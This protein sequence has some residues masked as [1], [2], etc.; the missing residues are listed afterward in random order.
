MPA[1]KAVCLYEA[2]L[3]ITQAELLLQMQDSD[4]YSCAR[5]ALTRLE[6][7]LRRLFQIVRSELTVCSGVRALVRDA[8]SGLRLV[9]EAGTSE[10]S[11]FLATLRDAVEQEME[12]AQVNDEEFNWFR[13]GLAIGA[14]S[15]TEASTGR[16]AFGNGGPRTV[17]GT[18][19][20]AVWQARDATTVERLLR[21]L[22]QDWGRLFPGFPSD[23]AVDDDSRRLLPGVPE[24]LWGWIALE[25]GLRN[26]STESNGTS[27]GGTS[28]P[29]RV[30][31]RGRRANPKVRERNR[32]IV[33]YQQGHPT[34]S[35]ERIVD[36]LLREYPDLT[37]HM[38]RNAL[39]A[40]RAQ[41]RN[42]RQQRPR[43]RGGQ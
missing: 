39:K 35:A 11:T 26:L 12:D 37:I 2:G 3:R 9:G 15:G 27:T 36:A 14:G 21:Q 5:A 18:A 31:Q 30:P 1:V 22:E 17:P 10:V 6:T 4:W 32:A 42:Q 24:H 33:A 16:L 38:V 43:G 8:K 28:R 20:P 29:R 23:S 40:A 13:L 34:T 19:R 7:T 25:V 41:G